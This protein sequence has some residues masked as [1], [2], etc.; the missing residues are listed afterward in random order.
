MTSYVVKA[1]NGAI[2]RS[3]KDLASAQVDVVPAGADVAVAET[4]D[5][6]CRLTAPVAGWCS[7]KVLAARRRR[8]VV[9][10]FTFYNEFAMLDGRP[11][12]LLFEQHLDRYAAYLPKIVHVVDDD[13]PA[14]DDAWVRE[15][16]Q[17][18]ALAAG[19]EALGL[20]DD[21]VVLLTDADEIVNVAC[22]PRL[23]AAPPKLRALSMRTFYYD[24]R[25]R[26]RDA[27]DIYPK[28]APWAELR[29]LGCQAA[30]MVPALETVPL[31]G[32]HLSYFGDE[33]FVRNK[34][35]QFAHQ[36]FNTQKDLRKV[37][38]RMRAGLN[39]TDEPFDRV[40]EDEADLPAH[41]PL[42]ERLLRDAAGAAVEA[43]PV[44]AAL[45]ATLNARADLRVPAAR[46]AQEVRRYARTARQA[47]QR[48]LDATVSVAM[49]ARA[50][51]RV[52]GVPE[53]FNYPLRLASKAAG[54]PFAWT[55]YAGGSGEMATALR[56]GEL[57]VAI[58]LTEAA[59][60][61]AH[62][63]EV[64]ILGA[65]TTTPLCWGVHASAAARAALETATTACRRPGLVA[66]FTRD[67]ALDLPEATPLADLRGEASAFLGASGVAR[68]PA[69]LHSTATPPE[70]KASVAPL[71][72]EATFTS[73]TAR[74]D[75]LVVIKFYAPWCRA[76]RGLA[77]KYERLSAEYGPKN[78]KFYEM[79]HKEVTAKG[80]GGVPP[81]HRRQ[82]VALVQ[83]YS[84]GARVELPLRAA[85][86]RAAEGEIGKV[87]DG[88]RWRR[89][90]RGGGGDDAAGRVVDARRS[91]QAREDVA[92]ALEAVA[93]AR[94]PS[95][96]VAVA[97]RVMAR[98]PLL[99]SL[100]GPELDDLA[101]EARVAEYDA[102]DVIV[103]EGD[104]GRR[105]F[106]IVDGECD[107]F[108]S[109]KGLGLDARMPGFSP[110]SMRTAY[111]ELTN[112]LGPGSYFGERG[113]RR[114]SPHGDDP[115][116]GASR[117]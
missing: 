101:A 69:A 65:Y 28:A 84:G 60:L 64:T 53:H 104:V 63:G 15:H 62:K 80:G 21:D 3:E 86:D 94:D 1:K 89:R 115:G 85:E 19:L 6:R 11:K 22:L 20:A 105:F 16:H 87:D 9:D 90:A 18:D 54:A 41:K 78:V 67:E 37:G 2:V 34:L 57:D 8:Q 72:D 108:E 73:A 26:W 93:P 45:A 83:F 27:W 112:T 17:R 14:T 39:L 103:T 71:P 95:D 68:R 59:A 10:A 70:Q 109:T 56:E 50:L 77:P 92:E 110:N 106:V 43:R 13:M 82:R 40:P 23:R 91:R 81:A 7:L 46:A 102:G 96:P 31:A 29:R 48:S 25:F 36:E 4:V 66:D 97:R 44:D 35:E 5:G 55:E 99:G 32:W 75:G 76:C 98:V 117:P 88:R 38:E 116:R 100:K 30:R 51:L 61:F 12:P 111:G 79:S 74:D 42:L 52:G 58:L 33:A 24:F 47:K 113:S 114:T 49:A 107:V